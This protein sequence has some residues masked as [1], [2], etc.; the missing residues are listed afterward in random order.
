MFEVVDNGIAASGAPVSN[1]V[2][3]NGR[4]YTVQVPRDPASG[5]LLVEGG[6][7]PQARQALANLKRSM[8]AAGG[9]LADVVQVLVYLVDAEDAPGMNAVYQEFFTPPYPN[10]A[11]VV[12]KS[13]LA[14]G[15][16]I[17]MVVHA[18]L[19]G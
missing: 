18:E 12:V 11:T 2:K 9:S 16:R 8:E 3:S 17:E 1:T 6:I 5:A 10:R 7:E 14:A 19:G 15:M 4:V 13:L